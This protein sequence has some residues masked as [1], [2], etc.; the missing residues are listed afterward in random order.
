VDSRSKWAAEATNSY[1]KG[2]VDA[3]DRDDKER[4]MCHMSYLTRGP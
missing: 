1:H 4:E 2:I 3:K